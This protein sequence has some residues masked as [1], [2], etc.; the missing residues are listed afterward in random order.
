MRL[1]ISILSKEYVVV[2]M[3]AARREPVTHLHIQYKLI[4][5]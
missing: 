4:H 1:H 3:R 5:C 2:L